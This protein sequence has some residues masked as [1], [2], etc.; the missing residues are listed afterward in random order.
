MPGQQRRW[1]HEEDLTP[2]PARYEPR[3]RGEPG[4]VGRLVPHP[5]GVPPRY[6]VL[7]P[8]HQQLSILRQVSAERQDGQAEHLAHEQVDDLEH[9]AS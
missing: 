6:R 4:P 2:A 9:P 3:Q 5:A 1:G 7:M 8:E